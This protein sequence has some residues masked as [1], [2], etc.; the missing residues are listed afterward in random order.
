MSCSQEYKCTICKQ[1]FTSKKAMETH[2]KMVHSDSNAARNGTEG[3]SSCASSTS[4]KE[5]KVEIP[6]EMQF[7]RSPAMDRSPIVTSHANSPPTIDR[8]RDSE[9]RMVP[10]TSAYDNCNYMQTGTTTVSIVQGNGQPESNDLKNFCTFY[11]RLPTQNQGGLNSALLA[12]AAAATEE[13]I[14]NYQ[15]DNP[16]LH[17]S[18]FQIPAAAGAQYYPVA[19]P[20]SYSDSSR[21]SPSPKLEVNEAA[22]ET[23]VYIIPD[24][25]HELSSESRFQQPNH[26]NTAPPSSVIINVPFHDGLTPP[27]SSSTSPVPSSPDIVDLP[28]VKDELSLPPRK[29]SK[30][31]L[32]SME[33]AK[34]EDTNF[35]YNSVI[36]YAKAAPIT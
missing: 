13:L 29:R 34:T 33:R 25:N 4:D 14:T 15:N 32:K 27:S 17:P 8:I 24:Y 21:S 2:I 18:K 11:P 12:A 10:P 3:E 26:V 9:V 16:L 5:N 23:A 30:M 31:I 20:S 22:D 36:H 19:S 6:S 28:V 7:P 1:T 35:R